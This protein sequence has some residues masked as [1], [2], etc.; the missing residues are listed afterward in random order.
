MKTT[1]PKLPYGVRQQCLCIV[2]DY[3]RMRRE[4]MRMRKDIIDAGGA[5][6][7]TYTA[8]LPSDKTEERR[9][10]MPGAHS[11]SR[12]LE[13][14]QAQLEALENSLT[15]RQVRAV[16]RAKA[17]VGIGLPDAL[18]DALREGIMINCQ[19]GRQYPFE[20]LYMTGICRADFYRH[21]NQF[22]REIAEELNL[23]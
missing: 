13:N 8:T 21:R 7:T 23:F 20:R 22:F 15:A 17:R 14:K 5:N 18:A 10:Y 9:A 4:Y 2:R 11:A 16:D 6:Y 1:S 3:D 19:N 12:P